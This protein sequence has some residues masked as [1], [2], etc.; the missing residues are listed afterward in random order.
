MFGALGLVEQLAGA[1]EAQRVG[2][3]LAYPGWVLDGPTGI[4]VQRWGPRDLAYLLAVA[5]PWRRPT[6]GVGLLD[7]T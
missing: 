7:G 2:R 3:E 1:T 5:F 6:I 4:G